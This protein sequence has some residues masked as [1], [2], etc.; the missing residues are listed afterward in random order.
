[1][2]GEP[3]LL[4]VRDSFF[5]SMSMYLEKA[6]RKKCNV[7]SIYVDELSSL[8]YLGSSKMGPLAKPF[9]GLML[10]RFLRGKSWLPQ[11][12]AVLVSDPVMIPMDFSRLK[13]PTAFYSMDPHAYRVQHV[14]RTHVETFDHV[15][16]AQKDYLPFYK[17]AGCG[18]AIWLPLA[19]DPE[20]FKSTPMKEAFDLCFVGTPR[21]GS[22]RQSFLDQVK[23][24]LEG[25]RTY[26]GGAFL[27]DMVRIHNSSKTVLNRSNLG[28]LTMRVFEA[29]SCGRLLLTDRIG[30]GLRELFTDE[31]HLIMYEDV[32]D[33]VELFK[34]YVERQD[35]RARIGHKGQ[36]EVH[37]KHT[38]DQRADEILKVLRLTTTQSS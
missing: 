33:L 35:D 15:L 32:D 25:Y 16:V 13:I 30:N 21:P 19:A 29:L 31:T 6:L 2:D 26:F 20:I 34:Y 7:V 9:T 27:R 17:E 11:V 3:W 8:Y 18:E 38:Y 24:K 10:S 23:V 1:M 5:F 14:R 22:E 36:E 37:A 4:F 28:E 12:D